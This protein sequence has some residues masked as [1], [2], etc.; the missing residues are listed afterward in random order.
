MNSSHALF[1]SR[2]IAPYFGAP[3]LGV[4]IKGRP[5]GPGVDRGVDRLHVVFE[6]VPVL[7]R[8]EAEGVADQVDDARLDRAQQPHV[9]DHL[10][11]T[12]RPSQTTKKVSLTPRL[13]RSLS[14]LIQNFAPSPL[15][16]AHNPNTSF[17][18]AKLTPIAA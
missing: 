17:S 12:F 16:P 2:M 7:A 13:R 10:G 14:T 18:P 8:G 3:L 5:G 11:Q 4:L 15:V 6:R 9:P 1:Q